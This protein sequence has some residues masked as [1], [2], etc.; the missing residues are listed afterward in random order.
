MAQEGFKRKLAAILSAD[1]AGF[2]RLMAEDETHTIQT[3]KKHRNII[4]DQVQK[5]SGRVVDSPGDNLLA[6]FPSAV[7]AVKCAVKIQ[8]KL[9]QENDNFAEDKGL[10]FR[11][12]I[13][14]GGI[15]QDGE[16]I[17]G[18]G[19]NVASRIEGLSDAG[20][21]C[22]SRNAYDQVK[23]KVQIGFEYLGENEAK[24]IKEPVRIY[25]VL[26]D[27]NSRELSE[28]EPYNLPKKPSIAVLPFDNMSDD[29][30]QEYFSD[31]M[32]EEISTRL[33]M[34][35]D[36][37]VIARNSTFFYKDK[38]VKIQ[39]VGQE[40]GVR[41]VLEGS[42]RKA[43]NRIRITAQLIDAATEG[44][45]W[46]KT[47]DR[48]FKDI[49]SLQ[50]EIAEQ[51]VSS[52]ASTEG[53]INVSEHA[54]VLHIPT[55]NL[56]AYDCLLRGLSH[57]FQYARGENVKA[58]EMCQR[59][60]ELDSEFAG[61]HVLLGYT[62]W[63]D[64]GMQWNMD[65]RNLIKGL[66]LAQKAISLDPSLPSA[67]SLMARV[68]QYKGQND[69]AIVSAKRAISLNPNDTLPYLA[70]AGVLDS[71]GRSED[72]V[73]N[74]KKAMYLNPHHPANYDSM[75][76]DAYRDL[77]HYKEA[78]ESYNA[79]LSRDPDYALA[80]LQLAIVCGDIGRYEK[81]IA[82]LKEAISR[83][84]DWILAY[85]G[86]VDMYLFQW[87]S[88]QNEELQ[89]LDQ[90]LV[91]AKKC[92]AMDGSLIGGP[93]LGGIY[94]YKHLYEK[95][96]AE[97]EKVIA[98]APESGDGYYLLG[99]ILNQV[100]RSGEAIK[101][102]DRA[103]QLNPDPPAGY[104]KNL[105]VAYHYSGLQ[106]EA[107]ATYKRVLDHDPPYIEAFTTHIYMAILYVELG[108]KEDALSEAEEILKLVPNFTVEVW[109]ER[110]PLKDRMIVEQNMAVLRKA[111]LK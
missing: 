46:A 73:E 12:G 68:Y 97:A 104:I 30:E 28:K 70:L 45:L 89:I 26:M 16:Q 62:Y 50:D 69:Q 21:I 65:P 88:Q 47:Y 77:G 93:R 78:I 54:R 110:S 20:G 80:Y 24:N 56:T 9:K 15:V 100:G 52:L 61:A 79:A 74:I 82:S 2:S 25:K 84:P 34:F 108:Q 8:K 106:A 55:E 58:R 4:S 19:V 32:T 44:H 96:I 107:M 92:V 43:G 22:I 64:I 99:I 60:I 105:G 11:I 27:S 71:V 87:I 23:D 59:A 102:L 29:P 39:K 3:L 63:I 51:I 67:H 103:I 91:L 49:F 5:H 72:A 38:S 83:D 57:F 101:M 86:L 6:E 76:V 35:S 1:V 94:L 40:L 48:D 13:N 36:L 17:Y 95:A 109:G 31:G 42:V 98:L 66:K 75:L 10:N 33:S 7:N 18:D 111:G 90:A 37:F 14:I 81:A 41:Y 53:V 85:G